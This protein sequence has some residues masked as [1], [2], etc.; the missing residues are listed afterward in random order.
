MKL[1]HIS[2]LHLG[3]QLHGYSLLEDQRDMLR[4]IVEYAEEE[5]PDALLICGDVYDRSVPSG[6]AMMLFDEFLVLL[7]KL[8]F[9]LPVLII[10]GNHDSPERLNYANSFLRMHDI[11]V[12][13]L[14]PQ[15]Q[16]E[17]LK[18]LEL[19]DEYGKVNLYMLPFVRRGMVRHYMP[20]E[21]G[22][23]EESI[24]SSLLKRE[25]I[26]WKERNVLLSHQFY[27]N[28]GK[29][30]ISC[31][32]EQVRT[33]VGGLD[34]VDIRVVSEFDYVA[35]GHI[36]KGQKIGTEQVRYSGTPMPY[37][38]SEAGQEKALLVVEL[39]EK[40]KSPLVRPIPFV[41][42]HEVRKLRGDLKELIRQSEQYGT[43]YVSLTCT[44]EEVPGNL[45]ALLEP[46]YSGILEIIVDNRK[47]RHILKEHEES[48]N[49]DSLNP[50]DMFARF[51]EE[52][53]GRVL[54][55]EEN[56]IFQEI[57]Q[58]VMEEGGGIR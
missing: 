43:D 37:S 44:E 35:L 2:D 38:V 34:A 24:I 41:Q 20:E 48:E 27:I 19:W 30:P 8:S 57:L 15:N 56:V 53:Q 40:G 12:S 52:T 9:S 6:E 50:G 22:E 14:P 11:H 45:K 23:G 32:S 26:D 18:K 17:R 13:V 31:D 46:Y 42:K 55:E 54:T 25:K 29:E 3:K 1:F 10:A 36:H 33:V 28:E 58:D 4:Q 7:S 47:S 49:C 5:R 16:D 21:A 39:G 51:F